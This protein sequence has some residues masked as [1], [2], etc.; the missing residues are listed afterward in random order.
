M[1][2]STPPTLPNTLT[3]PDPPFNAVFCNNITPPQLSLYDSIV[4][5][6]I[7]PQKKTFT[8]HKGL[9]CFHSSFFKAAFTGPYKEAQSGLLILEDESPT[10][11]SLFNHWAY[12]SSILRKLKPL[13][14]IDLFV[15][16]E[17]RLIRR[18]QNDVVDICI[19]HA[20][21]NDS[22]D[23]ESLHIAWRQTLRLRPL[24]VDLFI[25]QGDLSGARLFDG[26]Y[27]RAIAVRSTELLRV[28]RPQAVRPGAG[29]G[30]G[31]ARCAGLLELQC[32]RFHVHEQ[33]DPVCGG[34]R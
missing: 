8:M 24:L 15:F 10:V 4:E 18:L 20:S 33:E 19:W 27:L 34:D 2:A 23:E 26:D 31:L 5:I 9:L 14:L 11:F 16:A 1:V 21:Q 6:I 32:Y 13:V 17:T 30:R 29:S 12:D 3:I 25:A 28:A 22:M 7:G